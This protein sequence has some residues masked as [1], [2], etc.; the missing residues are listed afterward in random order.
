MGPT[1]SRTKYALVLLG[2]TVRLGR[3]IMRRHAVET[4]CAENGLRRCISDAAAI[5]R[6]RPRRNC[7]A[8][9]TSPRAG[10]E[11]A[12]GERGREALP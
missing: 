11:A 5:S 10:A 2:R 9:W 12:A 3:T 6:R 7:R 1:R 8:T 4:A